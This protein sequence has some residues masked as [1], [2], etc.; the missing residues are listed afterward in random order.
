MREKRG[1][2]GLRREKGCFDQT[3]FPFD[4]DDDDG[5][6]DS[7]SGSGS[8]SDSDSDDARTEHNIYSPTTKSSYTSI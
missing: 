3:I 6:F 7:G 8:G 2:I 5:G 1:W 4:D